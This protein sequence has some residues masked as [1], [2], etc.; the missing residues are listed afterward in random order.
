MVKL[1]RTRVDGR[2]QP[3]GCS[4]AVVVVLEEALDDGQRI[5]LGL[6]LGVAA[7]APAAARGAGWFRRGRCV[8]SNR[9]RA[10]PRLREPGVGGGGWFSSARAEAVGAAGMLRWCARA[11]GVEEWDVEVERR[12][13]GTG[14][15]VA[16]WDDE[17]ERR[18][19]GAGSGV[20]EWNEEVER[21][22]DG[23]GSG[24]ER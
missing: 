7:K 21:R 11:D 17:V 15:G 9:S 22:G 23:T 19:D 10:A 4:C 8:S 18:G 20:A 13:D 14:S 2:I 12:G 5:R 3:L 24:V 1:V 16:E 6:G